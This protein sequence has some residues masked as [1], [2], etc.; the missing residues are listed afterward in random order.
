M[1]A[2]FADHRRAGLGPHREPDRGGPFWRPWWGA[3]VYTGFDSLASVFDGAPA[4]YIDQLG[5]RPT[6]AMVRAS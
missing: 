2:V 4:Y 3:L 6:T 5:V 1:L